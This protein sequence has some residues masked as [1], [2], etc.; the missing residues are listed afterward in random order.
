VTDAH[1]M[2]EVVGRI[3]HELGTPEVV[4][5]N[6]VGG[7]FGNFQE[8]D[9][10]VV[11]RNFQ[12]N[13][14]ALLHLIRRTA[15][16]M[17][18]AGHGVII[19]SGNTSALRGKANFAGFAPT[20]A[21][22]RVLAESIARVQ[23]RPCIPEMAYPYGENLQVTIQSQPSQDDAKKY[24]KPDHDL[25]T[26]G[27][28]FTTLRSCWSPPPPDAARDG[29]QMSV[30]FSFKK[31]GRDDRASAHDLSPRRARRRI[32]EIRI[33]RRSTRRSVVASRSSS[34]P[35]SATPSPDVRS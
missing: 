16:S 32:S 30:L 33:W 23:P 29:M 2:D 4:I 28:L 18:E 1:Q 27:D 6:A 14:M 9:R 22:Q 34:R 10:T 35:G 26:I 19:A 31:S 24:Q 8:I 11:E 17:I 13:V 25:N 7:V 15:P 3:T 20:K 5:H 12:I 21:A